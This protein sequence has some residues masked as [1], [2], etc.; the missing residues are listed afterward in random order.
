MIIELIFDM[1]KALI[2][3]I[4]SLFPTFPSTTFINEFI[5]QFKTLIQ[6]VNRFISV[7]MVGICFMAIL[8]CYNARAIWSIVMWVI[9]KLPGVS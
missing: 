5:P 6:S 8:L 4:I 1:L 3:F 9:R 2:L 7:P